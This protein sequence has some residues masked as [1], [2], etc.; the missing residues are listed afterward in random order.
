MGEL[1]ADCS[2]TFFKTFS[3]IFDMQVFHTILKCRPG[4][5]D[6]SELI[7]TLK[8][9]FPGSL[10]SINEFEQKYKSDDAIRWYIK[11]PFIYRE[12]NRALRTMHIDLLLQYRF[13]LQDICLQLRKLMTE[14]INNE[15]LNRIS[16]PN[17]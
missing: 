5:S 3:C 12:L 4:L 8:E 9:K 14:Q 6:Q 13:V 7:K 10:K 16:R 15:N 2:F 11:E 17:N 1:F